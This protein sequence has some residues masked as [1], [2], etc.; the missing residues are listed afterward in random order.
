MNKGLTLIETVL[1]IALLSF[2]I[3]TA[4]PMLIDLNTWRSKQTA[5]ENAISEFVFLE[6]QIRNLIKEAD[7]VDVPHVGESSGE[8]RVETS[9][10]GTVSF[11]G[12][13]RMVLMKIGNDEPLPMH[14]SS[15]LINQINFSRS[16]TSG[17][18]QMLFSITI[19]NLNFGT[20]SYLIQY[21]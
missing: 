14:A 17:I 7:S 5:F 20:T 12:V 4:I 6:G 19:N 8:L 16:A 3:V 11:L 9:D 10:H 15:T 2:L 1:Y 13:N 18:D 21:E